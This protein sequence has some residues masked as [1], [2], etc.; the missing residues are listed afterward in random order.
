M[1]STDCAPHLLRFKR[2]V[3]QVIGEFPQNR[4]CEKVDHGTFKV[5]DYHRVL[6]MIFHQ[7]REGSFSFALA[8]VNCAPNLR[9]AKEY[10][11]HHADEEKL[12]WRWIL[13]DLKET[14]YHADSLESSLP[15]S[16]CQNYISFNYYVALKMP[17]ARLAI[18]MVLEGI[19]A[20]YGGEYA[21]KICKLLSLTPDQTQFYAGH[22]NTDREHIQDLW[23]VIEDCEMSIDQWQWMNHAAETAGRLYR[24]MY[25]E[26]LA[27]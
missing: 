13:N 1:S 8:A 9:N 17:I 21:A 6:R 19:G 23:R 27:N 5:G 12:H 3:E 4:V 24:S 22:G 14:G 20:R 26:A 7:V 2:T 15:L 18:A 25:E 11:L 16:A 10:L